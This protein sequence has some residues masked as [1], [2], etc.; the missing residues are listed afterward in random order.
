MKLETQLFEECK[1]RA[2]NCS[3]TLQA[4]TDYSV[5]IYRGYSSSYVKI[6]Y[7]DGH[8]DKNKAIKKALKFLKKERDELHRRTI[9]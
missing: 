1:S 3:L 5:E 9:R 8:I 6:F 4:I 2:Y 7:T